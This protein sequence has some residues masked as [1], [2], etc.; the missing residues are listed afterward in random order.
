LALILLPLRIVAQELIIPENPLKGRFVFEQ[1]GCITC[2]A[3]KGEGGEIGPDLGKKKFYGSFLQ[4]AGIMWNHSPEMLRRMRELDLPFPEFSRAEMV[5]LIAY[6]YYLRYLGEP[7]DLYRGKVLATEKGCLACHSIGGKGGKSGPAFDKLAKYVSPLYMAQ[8]LWNHGPQMEQ[9]IKKMGL[10]RP[11]FE[12]GEIVDLSAYIREASK[13]TEKEQV[14]MSPG[15]PQRGKMVFKEKGCLDCHAARGEGKD[16]GPDLGELE[17]DY[18]VTEIAG[19]MW[20]HGT[21]MGELMEE[22]KMSWPTFSGKE[23]ADLI[24][25]LYFLKFADK[26]GDAQAGRIV[27]SEKG[28]TKCHGVDGKGS[29]NAP[30]LSKSKVL[31]ST[32]DMAR[33]M[34]NHAPVMEERVTEKVMRWPEFSGNEMMNLYAFLRSLMEIKD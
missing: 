4:L 32:I 34:W 17:W 31:A 22:R 29:E 18:S 25:C 16:V 12:K 11:K 20:N 3:I 19:L 9:Q 21:E 10:S 33:I 7:G 5:E 14:Y 15:N 28:C 13:G 1:K 6:L 2:H 24:A 23:M 26:P 30:D 8:A 27:F